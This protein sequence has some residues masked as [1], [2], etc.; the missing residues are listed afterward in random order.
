MFCSHC[1]NSIRDGSRFCPVCGASAES[2]PTNQ[3]PP[4]APIEMPTYEQYNLYS[5]PLSPS[6]ESRMVPVLRHPMFL[7]SAL[8]FIVLTVTELYWRFGLFDFHYSN[9]RYNEA[10]LIHIFALG[11]EYLASAL[12]IISLLLQI[13]GGLT[14][15]RGSIGASLSLILIAL[16]IQILILAVNYIYSLITLTMYADMIFDMSGFFS[17]EISN[18]TFYSPVC[19]IT[20]I[21]AIKAT[22]IARS[23]NNGNQVSFGSGMGVMLIIYLCAVI[24][25]EL[26][27]SFDRFSILSFLEINYRI[28][29]PPLCFAVLMFM[30][31]RKK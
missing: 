24:L 26:P 27:F 4:A 2:T 7:F 18:V 31:R 6:Y 13:I 29:L 20:Y 22:A 12:I 28:I 21:F 8:V 11:L 30:V 14:K 10:L 17:Y 9:S 23:K 5:Q 1:G 16:V 3:A 15:S 19:L 25:R